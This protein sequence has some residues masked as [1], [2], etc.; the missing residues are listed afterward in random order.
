M[1]QWAAAQRPLAIQPPTPALQIILDDAE[2]YSQSIQKVA[3]SMRAYRP[4]SMEDLSSFVSDCNGQLM[5]IRADEAAV[6]AQFP[7]WPKQRWVGGLAALLMGFGANPCSQ[8]Q[9]VPA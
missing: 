1:H 3:A 5:A 8:L 4:R 6:L 7:Q 2:K 9:Q